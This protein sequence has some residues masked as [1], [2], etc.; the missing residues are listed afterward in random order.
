[1]QPEDRAL[2]R[3]EIAAVL[4]DFGST[5]NFAHRPLD[6]SLPCGLD[7]LEQAAADDVDRSFQKI[8]QLLRGEIVALTDLEREYA[9]LAGALDQ[10]R[11]SG[12]REFGT[13][14]ACGAP[15]HFAVAAAHD[16]VGEIARKFWPFRHRQQMALALE[17][18]D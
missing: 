10:R 2:R 12:L 14:I 18:R 3:R 11:I 7:P 13:G 9:I 16:H 15:D 8:L 5:G 17:A 1:M 4:D 6:I